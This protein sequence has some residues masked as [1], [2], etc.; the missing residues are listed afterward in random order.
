MVILLLPHMM[1]PQLVLVW[2]VKSPL[3]CRQL[4]SCCALR[5]VS[6]RVVWTARYNVRENKPSAWDREVTT[7]AVPGDS[8][9][10][11]RTY[12]SPALAAKGRDQGSLRVGTLK[13]RA[14]GD[15]PGAQPA[16]TVHK[17]RAFL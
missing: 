16:K 6:Q 15:S 14:H 2:D 4:R 9:G 8:A 5:S 3:A 13:S 7:L 10:Q 12:G 1:F 17:L 11:E